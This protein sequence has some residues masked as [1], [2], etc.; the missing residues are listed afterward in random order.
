MALAL[1]LKTDDVAHKEQLDVWAEEMCWALMGWL[2]DPESY[3]DKI[4]LADAIKREL[5]NVVEITLARARHEIS[6]A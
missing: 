6:E 3:D 5:R 2:K 4:A 1:T